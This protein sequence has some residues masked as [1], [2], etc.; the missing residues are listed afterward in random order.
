MAL[1]QPSWIVICHQ[2]YHF[3]SEI[4]TVVTSITVRKSVAMNFLGKLA[5]NRRIMARQRENHQC[6]RF[7]VDCTYIVYQKEKRIDKDFAVSMIGILLALVEE[8]G[9]QGKGF[10]QKGYAGKIL[11]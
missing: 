7:V 1:P 2:L 5:Q 11:V 3:L 9:K 6:R 4:V 8:K 10:A